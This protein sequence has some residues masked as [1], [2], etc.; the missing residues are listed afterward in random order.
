MYIDVQIVYIKLERRSE[1][2][3]EAESAIFAVR[4]ERERRYF[5][6]RTYDISDDTLKRLESS[7]LSG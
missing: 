3:S 5:L 4:R 2:K 7:K 6:R 1:M